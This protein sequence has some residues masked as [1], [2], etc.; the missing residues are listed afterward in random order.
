MTIKKIPIR[1]YTCPNCG[2]EIGRNIAG[3]DMR[4]IVCC[5]ER[6]RPK[7]VKPCQLN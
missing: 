4:C 2:R 3:A 5:H 6:Q 1:L 7:E